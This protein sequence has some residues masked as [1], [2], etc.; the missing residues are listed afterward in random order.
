MF[1]VDTFQRKEKRKETF[2]TASHRFYAKHFD[3]LLH[4][5]RFPIP[6]RTYSG[7][8]DVIEDTVLLPSY[9]TCRGNTMLPERLSLNSE[10]GHQAYFSVPKAANLNLLC[11]SLKADRWFQTHSMLSPAR[12]VDRSVGVLLQSVSLS[13]KL[14]NLTKLRGQCV[15]TFLVLRTPETTVWRAYTIWSA[16]VVPSSIWYKSS[17]L[18]GCAKEV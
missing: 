15:R 17:L 13:L 18:S 14:Q 6:L 2:N 1:G 5:W 16:W 10:N 11:L 4:F 3:A 9:R 8:W 12:Q 7:L